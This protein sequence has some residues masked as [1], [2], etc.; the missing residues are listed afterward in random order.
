MTKAKE[1]R[2]YERAKELL[3]EE[4]GEWF[5]MCDCI[6]KAYDE[7]YPEEWEAWYDDLGIFTEF[8]SLKPEG[9]DAR[10]HWWNKSDRQIRLDKF[11]EIIGEVK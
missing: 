9:K 8:Y 3:I 11:D 1:I 6:S 2:I 4:S 5:S 10:D 7:L